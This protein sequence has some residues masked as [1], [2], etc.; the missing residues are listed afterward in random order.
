MISDAVYTFAK[1]LTQ[2]ETFLSELRTNPT[3]CDNFIAQEENSNGQAILDNIN[4]VIALILE[5]YL[6]LIVR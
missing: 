6:M 5:K 2:N 1:T 3:G 4:N